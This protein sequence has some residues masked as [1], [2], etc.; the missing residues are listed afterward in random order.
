MW[1]LG[2]LASSLV[3]LGACAGCGGD[4]CLER[5]AVYGVRAVVVDRAGTPVCDATL[6]ATSET[7][8]ETLQA[9]PN[10]AYGG[11]NQQPGSFTLTAS[12]PGVG[13]AETGVTVSMGECQKVRTEHVE[14]TLQPD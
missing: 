7:Y 13:S 2:R 1:R 11:L 6:T 5:A 8:S 14:L 9:Y 12:K 3:V 4:D 10:C